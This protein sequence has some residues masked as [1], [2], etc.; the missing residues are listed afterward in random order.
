M[1]VIALFLD[2]LLALAAAGMFFFGKYGVTR[3]LAP[4]PMLVAVLD[5]AFA[6]QIQFSLTATLSALLLLL[7]L[8]VLGGSIL[9]LYQDRV[10]A[11]NK[12]NRRRRR[13]A[14]ARSRAVFEQTAATQ[15]NRRIRVCA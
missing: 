12:E 8:V 3:Q 1:T 13:K 4:A 9:V 6:Q 2:A 11:R 10:R 7:Q 15:K 14:M 5:A